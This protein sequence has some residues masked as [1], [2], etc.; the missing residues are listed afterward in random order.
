M[1]KFR[2]YERRKQKL[3]KSNLTPKEYEKELKKIVKK[4]R[5]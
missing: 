4:L 1:N 3:A 5:I 2:R